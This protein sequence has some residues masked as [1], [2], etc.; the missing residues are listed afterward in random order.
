VHSYREITMLSWGS[1]I[2]HRKWKLNKKIL[3]RADL[4][5]REPQKKWTKPSPKEIKTGNDSQELELV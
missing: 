2:S 4:L 3:N 5:A 1:G